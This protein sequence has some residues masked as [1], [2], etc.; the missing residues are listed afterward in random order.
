MLTS[1]VSLMS[2]IGEKFLKLER[3]YWTENKRVGISG[4]EFSVKDIGAEMLDGNIAIGL[5]MDS[6]FSSIN[7]FAYKK[8]LEVFSQTRA[9]GLVNEDE[10]VREI[11]R[12][13]GLSPTRF[14]PESAPKV[15]PESQIP[16]PQDVFSSG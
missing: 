5:Q 15:T 2:E 1:F 6:M 14:V 7:E 10:I 8:I 3:M 4:T 16:A 9:T 12:T 11:F 13:Q